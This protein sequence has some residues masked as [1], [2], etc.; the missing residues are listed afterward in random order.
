VGNVTNSG[1]VEPNNATGTGLLHVEGDYTQTA[2]GHLF[3]FADLFLPPG[4][5]PKLE[6]TGDLTLDGTLHMSLGGMGQFRGTRSFDVLDWGGSLN[7]TT[8]SSVQLPTNGGT[9][10]W[11]PSQLY[12]TGVL[13]LTGPPPEADFNHD[14][15]VDA[16]DY[17]VW[18]KNGGPQSDYDLWRSQFGI[19]AGSGSGSGIRASSASVPEPTTLLLAILAASCCCVWRQRA[20]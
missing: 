7:G 16:A 3:F 14:G 8:F 2:T 15:V 1:F 19:V 13:I 20:A 6:V 17:V 9:F 18:R 4:Q 10:T 11:D 5:N 12:T